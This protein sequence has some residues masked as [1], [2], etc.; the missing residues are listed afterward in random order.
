MGLAQPSGLAE[1][2]MLV[3][4]LPGA[5]KPC[6]ESVILWNLLRQTEPALCDLGAV[7]KCQS[8]LPVPS[9][10][11]TFDHKTSCP[12]NPTKPHETLA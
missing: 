1:V 8:H 7:K 10:H 3:I 4:G 11:K 6:S 12:R 5:F 2:T 9:D